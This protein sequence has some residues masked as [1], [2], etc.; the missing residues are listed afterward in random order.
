VQQY[1][2]LGGRRTPTWI[3]E[4]I[5]DY[6]RWEMYEPTPRF[7]VTERNVEKISYDQSYQT[8]ADFLKWVAG[9]Y[10]KDLIP[11]LNAAARDGSY[12]EE[13]WKKNTGHS[14][15][16]LGAEWK[17]SYAEKLGVALPKDESSGS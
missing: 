12:N 2:F 3:S 7:K 9:K 4:G 5:A 10:D 6:V 17:A 1:W 14:V 8:T 15:Q 13:F 11:Q 16:E